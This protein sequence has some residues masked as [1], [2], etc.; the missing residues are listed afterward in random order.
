MSMFVTILPASFLP[1][2]P[3]KVRC[4]VWRCTP[5]WVRRRFV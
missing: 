1:T 2:V 3:W 4:V 5:T